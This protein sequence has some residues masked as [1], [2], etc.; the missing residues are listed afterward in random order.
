MTL[1]A[2]TATATSVEQVRSRLSELAGRTEF[3]DRALSRADPA[4]LALA[5]PHDVYVL[6]LDDV[7]DGTTLAAARLVGRRF[8]VLDGSRAI[9]G[10]EVAD[11]DARSGFQVNEGPYVEATAAAIAR[12][13]EDP[14]LAG[15]DHE[16]RLLRVP[17]L[18]FVGLWL[19]SDRDR[20]DRVIP[21]DPAPAH[22]EAG[23][24]Q[25]PAVLLSTLADHARRTGGFDDAG[26]PP[27]G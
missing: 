5:A 1:R 11:P 13:E 14:D 7:V 22:L 23:R 9:A 4:G 18:H 19:K 3:Q 17:A 12:A 24:I 27:P 25:D 20:G 6:G 15:D 16:V 2:A 21:L 26:E 10:V 8:L